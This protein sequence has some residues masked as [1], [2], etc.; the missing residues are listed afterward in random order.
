MSFSRR[1]SGGNFALGGGSAGPQPE[2]RDQGI[3]ECEQFRAQACKLRFDAVALC[4]E[5]QPFRDGAA[6]GDERQGLRRLFA[7]YVKKGPPAW[8]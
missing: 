2:Q 7:G 1:L 6:V 4:P 8:V 5:G 3:F